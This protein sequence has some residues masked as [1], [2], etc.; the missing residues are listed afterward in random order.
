MMQQILLGLGDSGPNVD[1]S[2]V[3][4]ITLYTGTGGTE[5]IDNDMD[6]TGGGMLWIKQRS[7][8]SRDNVIADTTQ[9]I[10]QYLVSNN[11]NGTQNNN[12][13]VAGLN[14]DGFVVKG[15]MRV[16]ESGRNFVAWTWLDAANFFDHLQ[17]RGNGN[18]SQSISH[19]LG[20]SPGM[21]FIK[22]VGSG[23]H[24]WRVFHKDMGVDSYLELNDFDSEN[25]SESDI[26]PALPSSTTFT[27]GNDATVGANG[28]DYMAYLFADTAGV[29][30]CGSYDGAN[31][32][33]SVD[34]G[35][36]PQ[37][38]MIKPYSGAT[39]MWT[40]FDST[41]GTTKQL[42]WESNDAESTVDVLS[43]TSTG[44]TITGSTANHNGSGRK[45]IFMAIAAS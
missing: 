4:D 6:Y 42:R 32:N 12:N 29:I 23:S 27:V 39:G 45:F 20:A 21:I 30:K 25:E 35:F 31:T 40:V 8:N 22:R 2:E 34:C 5:G 15:D 13:T 17:Y 41:R 14:N 18:S 10:F 38:L 26:F 44:F 36:Q 3:F 19:S 33:K 7:A 37:F 43:F 28:E 16:G 9:G 24:N 11:A 1:V